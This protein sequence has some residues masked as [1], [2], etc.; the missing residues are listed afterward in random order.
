M[1]QTSG[2]CQKPQL[3]GALRNSFVVAVATAIIAALVALP[4]AY[5]NDRCRRMRGST[6][7]ACTLRTISHGRGPGH[8]RCAAA[9]TYKDRRLR[10]GH[11]NRLSGGRVVFGAGLGGNRGE[12]ERFG[13]SFSR[14]RRVELLTGGSRQL[15]AWFD[16]EEVDGVRLNRLPEGE[17]PDLDRGEQP[18]HA[19]ARRPLRRLVRRQRRQG[20]MTMTPDD[21]AA[22]AAAVGGGDIVVHGYS[23]V[24]SAGRLRRRGATWWLENLNDLYGPPEELRALVRG[25]G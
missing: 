7:A 16:G 1:S 5:T 15:R 24:A 10:L 25:G 14:R 9:T 21:V 13:E 4:A 6:L 22:G 2:V 11:F 20:R 23:R 3:P 17:D 12:F 18:G 8:W 19:R